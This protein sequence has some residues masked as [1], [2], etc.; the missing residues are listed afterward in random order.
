M[1]KSLGIIFAILICINLV[2]CVKEI[3]KKEQ[4]FVDAVIIKIDGNDYGYVT[5]QYNNYVDVIIDPSVYES[6]KVGDTIK[7]IKTLNTYKDNTKDITFSK[8]C[9]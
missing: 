3:S 5:I 4:E 7:V 1:K 2:G 8:A 6:K 9:T